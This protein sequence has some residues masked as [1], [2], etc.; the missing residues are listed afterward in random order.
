MYVDGAVKNLWLFIYSRIW[1]SIV[2]LQ[3]L[4]FY[5]VRITTKYTLATSLLILPAT[6]QGC[7]NN[8]CHGVPR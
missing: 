2:G 3:T 7:S 4:H 5:Y 6:W 1:E 8:A